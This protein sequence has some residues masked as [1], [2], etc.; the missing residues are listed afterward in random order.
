MKLGASHFSKLFQNI[1]NKTNLFKVNFTNLR[2][3]K[4]IKKRFI[5]FLRSQSKNEAQMRQQTLSFVD[6]L[7]A[8]TKLVASLW[9]GLTKQIYK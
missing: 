1:S 9:A 8:S 6:Q 3:F 2:N 7:F 5:C 4:C